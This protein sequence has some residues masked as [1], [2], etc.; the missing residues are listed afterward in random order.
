VLSQ[1]ELDALFLSLKVAGVATALSIP[2]GIFFAWLL[3]KKNFLGKSF[4]DGF[5]NLPLILPPVVVGYILLIS[6]G[7]NGWLGSILYD[8]FDISF[9]FTWKGAV[10]AV[11]TISFPLMLRSIR[12][13]IS[14]VDPRLEE[15]ARTLGASPL[16]A[17]FTITLP[18]ALPGILS[19]ALISFARSLGEFGAT[20][21]FV[22][23][24][25][26]ET[27]TIPLAI[28]SFIETPGAESSA[29]RLSLISVVIAF[30]S[31]IASEWIS[32]KNKKR[33]S[34]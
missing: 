22:S 3:A 17:F 20:I 2:F 4:V 27:Q 13:G 12:L 15:A 8:W 32:R 9:A 10:I 24:I 23:N 19:G 6:L 30:T 29:A 1:Y 16:R 7:K 18:L 26:K 5:L 31:I 34:K 14:S 33:V 21:T 11:A 25:P 28:Y